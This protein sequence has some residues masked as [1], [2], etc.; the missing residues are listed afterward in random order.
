MRTFTFLLMLA[1]IATA[2]DIVIESP[3]TRA[4]LVELFTS[5]GCSS[6]PPADEW[7]RSLKSERGLWREFVPVAFH[8]NYWDHLGWTDRL[9]SP[10]FTQRQ[11]D[12]AALWRSNSVYTPGFVLDG[13][14]WRGRE[15]PRASQEKAG[16]LRVRISGDR[17]SVSY[18]R[19]GLDGKAIS[20][21]L[22]WLAG[23]LERDRKSVV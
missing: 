18:P 23:D 22:V 14:E 16:V 1:S 4:H 3:T 20:A 5:E 10:R 6:C 12:Y 8:V 11:R 21:H 19:D 15:L 17:A 13:R 2:G 9:A 7:M